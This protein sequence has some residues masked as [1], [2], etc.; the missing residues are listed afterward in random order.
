[1]TDHSSDIFRGRLPQMVR[2]QLS[3]LVEANG[4]AILD[5]P[6]RVRAM[7]RDTVATAKREISL[8]H[9]ALSEGVPE[10]LS[11]VAGDPLRVRAEIAALTLQLEQNH[12][13]HH[14]AAQWA[15]R[16][17]AWSLQLDVPPEDLE[18]AADRPPAAS[19]VPAPDMT[20]APPPVAPPPVAPP[21]AAPPPF[22]PPP[23][24]PR[25]VAPGAASA[26]GPVAE[27]PE[28]PPMWRNRSA[29][30]AAAGAVTLLVIVVVAAILVRS[31][32]DS[33]DVTSGPPSPSV[34]AS[35]TPTATA[36]EAAGFSAQQRSLIRAMPSAASVDWC[37]ASS[38]SVM[39]CQVP[40]DA[41]NSVSLIYTSVED[42]AE[43][44]RII[45]LQ[46]GTATVGPWYTASKAVGGVQ[47]QWVDAFSW[48]EFR[49][50]FAVYGDIFVGQVRWVNSD[51]AALL[52][53]W[54]KNSSVS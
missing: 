43:A 47:A 20:P 44:E 1:M 24:A 18:P 36:S 14:D 38:A 5:E 7:L 22:A 17:C 19:P 34:V 25:P 11:A 21:P 23:F 28:R 33:P 51:Q 9:V 27:E 10:R 53:W 4:K 48:A 30:I 26:S 13:L 12:A 35:T 54:Q 49:W 2:S 50:S 45:K 8:I 29:Q 42:Q 31:G 40:L 6:D 15:V 41:A 46:A 16:S 39:S 32:P 52:D 37:T 3:E